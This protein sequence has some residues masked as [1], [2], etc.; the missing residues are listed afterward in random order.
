MALLGVL[1]T[2]AVGLAAREPVF[3][4]RTLAEDAEVRQLSPQRRNWTS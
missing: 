3:E 1:R 4:E 2:G